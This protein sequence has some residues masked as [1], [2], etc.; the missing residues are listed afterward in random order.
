MVRELREH[1]EGSRAVPAVAPAK[2]SPTLAT[3]NVPFIGRVQPQ[4]GTL[5]ALS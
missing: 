1:Q 3:S 2:G 4:P 5:G